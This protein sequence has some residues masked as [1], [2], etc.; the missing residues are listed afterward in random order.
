MQTAI[1]VSV[2]PSSHQVYI[3]LQTFTPL[4]MQLGPFGIW[5]YRK[6]KKE[7]VQDAME[8]QPHSHMLFWMHGR[9]SLTTCV[10]DAQPLSNHGMP[11]WQI[12]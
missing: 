8:A 1:G 3:W 7:P 11:F 5:L 10:T 9:L 6:H 12:R 2:Y 4:N